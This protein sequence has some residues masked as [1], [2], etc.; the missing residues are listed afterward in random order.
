MK[1]TKC[2]KCGKSA[3]CIWMS[4]SIRYPDIDL[5]DDCSEKLQKWVCKK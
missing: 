4:D 1:P 2:F 3:D 5:C